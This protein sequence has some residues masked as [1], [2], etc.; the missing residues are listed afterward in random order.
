MFRLSCLFLLVVTLRASAAGAQD[1]E[2]DTTYALPEITVLAERPPFYGNE[3]ASHVTRI[4]GDRLG[5]LGE[6]TVGE[7]LGQLSGVFVRQYGV[8]G[9]AGVSLR[10]TG[11]GQTAVLLDGLPL[12]NPQLGQIDLSLLPTSM[13]SGIEVLHG[14]ASSLV[15]SGAI[16][17]AISLSSLEAGDRGGARLSTSVGSWGERM[18]AGRVTTGVR[19]L[20]AVLATEL[21]SRDGDFPY[22]DRRS[23][24]ETRRLRQNADGAA[25]NLLAKLV[26]AGDRSTTELAAWALDADRG[27]PGLA[28]SSAGSERQRDRM[29]RVWM[30]FSRGSTAVSASSQW[31][32]L[33]YVNPI[34]DLKDTGRFMTASLSVV[35]AQSIASAFQSTAGLEM[36]AQTASHPSLRTDPEQYGLRVFTLGRLD[37]GRFSLLPSV[38]GDWISRGQ[39]STGRISPSLRLRIENI[40]QLP[41]TLKSGLSSSFRAP[42][43]NDLFWRG[44]GATGNRDLEAERGLSADVGAEIGTSRQSI[45]LS[46][47]YQHVHD[48]ITWEPT[49]IGVWS[50]RNI[51]RVRTVGLEARGHASARLG[52]SA[53]LEAGLHYTLTDARDR[54]DRADA[55]FG[56]PLRH[57]PRHILNLEASAAWRFLEAGATIRRDGRRYLT[58]DGS[59][60]LAPHIVLDSSLSTRLTT[61]F[62]W[63][64]IS[65]QVRNLGGGEYEIMSG[66]PMPPR[67]ARLQLTLTIR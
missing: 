36:T 63:V 31:S 45:H 23:F 33:T 48:Q 53:K 28:G 52:Q 39:H 61:E 51:G 8:T 21:F 35:R 54:S 22:T 10:G 34:L 37:L 25:R 16:G 9:S 44:Q 42:T 40:L 12:E 38:R 56:K 18:L 64:D 26:V 11:T 27:L 13:L 7:A 3:A 46:A 20:R 19:R 66:Y 50:P 2:R 6:R 41:L 15:G 57:I 47:F 4:D 29:G 24:P 65:V 30:R 55:S 17:G 49:E 62:G 58:A 32:R 14:G 59:E 60:W 1:S 43:F 67:H 5:T